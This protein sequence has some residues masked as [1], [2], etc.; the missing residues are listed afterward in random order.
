MQREIFQSSLQRARNFLAAS[1]NSDGGWG[2]QP[3]KQSFAEPTCYALL[4]LTENLSADERKA[5]ENRVLGWLA[6]H[7]S[8]VGSLVAKKQ[9]GNALD[10]QE[11]D[12][13]GTIIAFYALRK[14]DIGADLRQRHLAY[15]LNTYGNQIDKNT[16]AMLKLNGDLRAWSWARGTASWVEPTA[17]AVLALKANQMREHERVKVG[18]AYLLDRAC[19]DGGWNYGN[20][21]VLQVKLEPMPTNTCFALLAL[22]DIDRNNEIVKKSVAYL[23]QEIAAR[24]SSMLL[25]LGAMCLSIYERPTEKLLQQLM[26]R[27]QEN[28]SWRDN[29]HL[30]ALAT[31]ALQMGA[32]TQNIFK[33]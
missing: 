9:N 23:E 7:T 32:T 19:Y 21:E 10:L 31:L 24:Q 4:A 17:Y 3:G 26:A 27:Q 28:G 16:S 25:A 8:T 33:L 12:N 30:T 20:K 6:E 11:V 14:L 29:M 22:Q 5:L 2:Y 13:W 15:L 18:E 1:Q